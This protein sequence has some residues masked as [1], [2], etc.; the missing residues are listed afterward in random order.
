ML[1]TLPNSRRSFCAV[2]GPTPGTSLKRRLGLALAATQA[3]EGYGEAMGFVANLLDEMQHRRVAI[4][5]ARLVFLAVDVEDL[6]FLGD[7]GERLIDDLQGLQGV[8]GGVELADSAVDQDQAGERLLLF[9]HAAI[10][11]SDGFVHAGEVVVLRPGT[12]GPP[13]SA[14]LPANSPRMMNLR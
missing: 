1:A 4:E 14:P 9:L 13:P 5:N 6:F 12:E 8:G 11:A 7:A 3:V 2:R 10:A